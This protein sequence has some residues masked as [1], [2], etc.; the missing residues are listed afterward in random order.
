MSDTRDK[1][2]ELLHKARKAADVYCCERYKRYGYYPQVIEASAYRQ[3]F[4]DALTAPA[5]PTDDPACLIDCR[6]RMGRSCVLSANHCTRR[7]V[8]HYDPMPKDTE[9]DK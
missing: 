7:A 5:D 2:R 8:D 9:A 6:H 3:G 1:E 4:R